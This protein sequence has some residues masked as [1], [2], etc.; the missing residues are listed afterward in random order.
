MINAT[1][2]PQVAA[3]MAL[4][5]NPYAASGHAVR[6]RFREALVRRNLNP[7]R[8]VHLC[9]YGDMAAMA[10][11]NFMRHFNGTAMPWVG[12][13]ASD[14]LFAGFHRRGVFGHL[15]H[16]DSTEFENRYE[17][18]K[19][20]GDALFN[21]MAEA[22][23]N[24]AEARNAQPLGTATSLIASGSVLD[25]YELHRAVSPMAADAHPEARAFAREIWERI[26]LDYP[27]IAAAFDETAP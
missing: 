21:E 11:L 23:V 14:A 16:A 10:A 22:G 25:F 8:L 15:F 6:S 12:G 9:F 3:A 19:D 1:S 17:A 24:P 13:A 5:L 7:F 4:G 26:S 2:N 20:T 27:D 18:G